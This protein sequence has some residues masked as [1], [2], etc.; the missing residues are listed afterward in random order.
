MIV[1]STKF[2]GRYKGLNE[3]FDKA[4]AFVEDTDLSSLETGRHEISGSDVFALVQKYTTYPEADRFM[5]VH[6]DYADVQ[7]MVSGTEAIY[8]AGSSEGM[9]EYQAYIKEKDCAL[10]NS[11][12]EHTAVILRDGEFAFLYPGELHKPCCSL[13]EDCEVAKIVIKIKMT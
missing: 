8:F 10:Y 1:D 13:N 2:M 12:I 11:E 9:D 4:I 5:E 6:G 3:G 7:I